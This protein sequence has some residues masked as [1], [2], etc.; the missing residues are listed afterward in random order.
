MTE[1]YF[2]PAATIARRS[3]GEIIFRELL[4]LHGAGQF[5]NQYENFLLRVIALK[6]THFKSLQ[7]DR[8]LYQ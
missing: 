4:D 2:S 6:C 5:V 3:H 1:M 7:S 8:Q